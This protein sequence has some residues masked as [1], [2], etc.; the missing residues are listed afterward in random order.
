[1]IDVSLR[2]VQEADLE[3]LAA[4]RS[5]D[6]GS[7]DWFGFV[8]ANALQRRFAADGMISDDRGLLAVETPGGD[9]AGEVSWFAVPHGPSSACRALNIGIAL[10]PEH[11][12]RGYGSAAQRALA[13]YLFATMLIERVEAETDA[14]N[15]AEQRALEKAG[16]TREGVLRSTQFR[17]GQWRDTVLYSVLRA[18]LD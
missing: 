14:D 6:A 3:L 17:D 5:R 1:V 2:P 12:N 7:L 16:F 8:P 4:N 13:R 10:L 15:I 11:R 9:L 18:E